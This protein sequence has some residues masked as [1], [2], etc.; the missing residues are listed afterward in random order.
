MTDR[1]SFY[2]EYEKPTDRYTII[3]K[4]DSRL[5]YLPDSK[6]LGHFV[7]L[8]NNKWVDFEGVKMI[9]AVAM[10]E[11]EYWITVFPKDAKDGRIQFNS[12][13]NLNHVNISRS[14]T[15][16]DYVAPTVLTNETANELHAMNETLISI[17]DILDEGI[18]MIILYG[19]FA[20]CLVLGL[21]YVSQI[22]LMSASTMLSIIGFL[23]MIKNSMIWN[24]T[25]V[26]ILLISIAMF[27]NIWFYRKGQKE[28]TE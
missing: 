4:S 24:L 7:D 10:T 19:I 14:F 28:L 27:L 23:Y 16:N 20:I 1:Y 6:Y 15:V 25:G 8:A 13:G 22:L 17:G 18:L 2:Y 3:L 26:I 21:K 11:K 12:I 5:T 9:Q